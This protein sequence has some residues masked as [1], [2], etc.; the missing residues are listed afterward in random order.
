MSAR[1]GLQ[2]RGRPDLRNRG[3]MSMA[4]T[5]DK[6]GNLAGM[7]Y[8]WRKPTADRFK[9]RFWNPE[10]KRFFPPKS[11]GWG[12]AINFYWLVHPVEYVRTRRS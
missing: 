10:N 3:V 11:F 8:D 6:Q 1:M 4:K 9:S 2:G 12:Y 5:G 7:P